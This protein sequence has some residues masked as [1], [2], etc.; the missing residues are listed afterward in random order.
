MTNF[1]FK[2][3]CSNNI[4]NFKFSFQVILDPT[5][6]KGFEWTHE[7]WILL[8]PKDPKTLKDILSPL[9]LFFPTL[10]NKSPM[11][12][13]S[14]VPTFNFY[15]TTSFPQLIP[16]IDITWSFAF[17]F[18]H[19][20]FKSSVVLDFNVLYVASLSLSGKFNLGFNSSQNPFTLAIVL[21]LWINPV[22]VFFSPFHTRSTTFVSL[23]FIIDLFL[24]SK[25]RFS[26]AFE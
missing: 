22:H 12:N 20:S 15:N 25:L 7:F 1:K 18:F 8:N 24:F 9:P 23:L 14:V 13:S 5:R 2:F 26:F 10:T 11:G 19:F 21:Y 3:H 16:N 4:L 6:S 17:K